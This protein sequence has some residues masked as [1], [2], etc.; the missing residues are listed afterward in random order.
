MVFAVVDHA[1]ELYSRTGLTDL[2][3]TVLSICS[4][5]PHIV[6]ASLRMIASFLRAF[7]LGKWLRLLLSGCLYQS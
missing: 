5:A 4:L 2:S 6:P 3:Y 7:S 1:V